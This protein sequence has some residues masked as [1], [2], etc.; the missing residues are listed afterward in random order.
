MYWLLLAIL[1]IPAIEIGVFI[2]IGGLTSPWFVISMIILTGIAGAALAKQQGLETLRRARLAMNIGQ[3]PGREIIHGI[4][5]FT[6]AIFL[7]APGFITDIVG[8]LLLF[9]WP[10]LLIAGQVEKTLKTIA[11]KKFYTFRK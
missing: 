1:V 8:F 6:G 2:W 3:L 11:T 9:P 4:C 7:I 10:R 5:I